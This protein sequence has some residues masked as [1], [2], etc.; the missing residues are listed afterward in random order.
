MAT[1]NITAILVDDH[2]LFRLGVRAGIE[3]RH[4]DIHIVGEA[5]TGAKLFALLNSTTADILLLDILLPDM[6]GIEIACRLKKEKPEMKILVISSENSADAIET[7]LGTGIE[8]FISKRMGGTEELAHAIRSIM[9]GFEYFGK[10][11]SE[12]IYR[13]YVS[14]KRTAEPSAEFTVQERKIIELCRNGLPS[15][16]IADHLCIS[17][18]TVENHKNNIFRKLGINNTIAMLQYA[19]KHGIIGIAILLLIIG[20]SY[21]PKKEV[22][23]E[24]VMVKDTV[25]AS[26]TDSLEYVLANGK[27]PVLQQM[28]ICENLSYSLIYRDI[29]KSMH[30]AKLGLDL[31][32]QEKDELISCLL[33]SDMGMIHTLKKEYDSAKIYFDEALRYAIRLK[34]ENMESFLYNAFGK[35]YADQWNYTTA[36]EYYEKALRLAEKMGKSSRV[37]DVMC[38]IGVIYKRSD[39][40]EEA[41][42]YF[43]KAIDIEVENLANPIYK[44]S[45]ESMNR[46]LSY[47]YNVLAGI[48]ISQQKYVE[49]LDIAQKALDHALLGNSKYDETH[50]LLTLS[51]IYSE[52]HADYNKALE[53]AY[54]GLELTEQV[55]I[56]STK[57]DCYYRLGICHRLA[58]NYAKSETYLLQSIALNDPDD[59]ERFR[60]NERELVTLY[61][62]TKETDKLL[63]AFHHYDSL[64]IALNNKKLQY[65]TSDL[66]IRYETEKK[67]LEIE[68][69]QHVINKQNLQR[70][71]LTAGVAISVVF[72][73]LLWYMLRLRTR[74]NRALLELNATKDKFFS[75]ISHDLKNPA[76]AQRD[77]LQLLLDNEGLWDANTLNRYYSELLKT[78]DG[79]VNLLYNLL[80]WAQVQTG[81][82]PYRPALFD[83]AAELRKTDMTLLHTMAARKE[84]TLAV[85][86]PDTVLV[87]G[88]AD[89]LLTVIRNLLVNAVKFTHAGGTVTLSIS[90]CTH[91]RSPL[92]RIS[93]SD[94]GIGMTDAQIQ[95]LFSIDSTRSQKGTANE[96]GSGL[97]L[98]VCKELLQKHGSTLH[99]ES[100]LNEGSCFWF[101]I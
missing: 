40:F 15:K 13:I 24:N 93:I 99:V 80:N 49:A 61:A 74:R 2:E 3:A 101:E 48:Y 75:I 67:E 79:Q 5:E 87:I 21:S 62:Q 98:I 23:K 41:E 42:K 43:L 84:V 73:A 10:D 39:N 44:D 69:Q 51:T 35:L 8:G 37:A 17:P 82:M 31:S 64:Y 66:V 65:N 38:N 100:K 94:T 71:L 25:F 16:Q 30:Y 68:R 50:A 81:R 28:K 70:R 55:D 18:R 19:M 85:D 53:F 1:D 14:K 83:I 12:I 63:D 78:A 60:D 56:E 27:L 97:G 52:Y 22:P 46:I 34:N 76:I 91:S 26:T 72:L 20:C 11:I 54:R 95:N 7:L 47:K 57:A 29:E 89:M 4:P 59:V 77:A 36:I 96:Q 32:S 88:D 9:S 6:S 58:G 86:M 92:H 45:Y 33:N 90:P